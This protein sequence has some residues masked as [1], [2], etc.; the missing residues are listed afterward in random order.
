M[1]GP[2]GEQGHGQSVSQ[3]GRKEGRKTGGR[4]CQ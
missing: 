2:L 3:E 1:V 4:W